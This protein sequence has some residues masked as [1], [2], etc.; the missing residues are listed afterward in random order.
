V[1]GLGQ[2]SPREHV[3]NETTWMIRVCC[4]SAGPVQFTGL[5]RASELNFR[6][7]IFFLVSKHRNVWKPTYIAEILLLLLFVTDCELV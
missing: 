5:G 3:S 2:Y 1:A 7:R 4:F 6:V